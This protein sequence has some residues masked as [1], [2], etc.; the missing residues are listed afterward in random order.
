MHTLEHRMRTRRAHRR[1]FSLIE[2]MVGTCCVAIFALAFHATSQSATTAIQE[3]SS[4]HSASVRAHRWSETCSQALRS[5]CLSTLRTIPAGFT[6]PQPLAENVAYPNLRFDALTY[7]AANPETLAEADGP[8]ILSCVA[9][10]TDP[11]NGVDDDGD[12]TADEDQLVLE[13]PDGTTKI[14]AFDV[15]ALSITK[16]GRKLRISLQS[17]Q[18]L[19]RKHVALEDAFADVEI[20]N[21]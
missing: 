21:D 5:A 6:T 17:A 13:R 9:S 11:D 14:V 16:S 7:D 12:G 8:F 1:G 4:R 19:G 20:R 15:T 18:N 2:M 10:P 3:N